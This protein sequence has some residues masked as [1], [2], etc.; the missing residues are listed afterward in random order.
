MLVVS[1]WNYFRGYVIIRIEGLALEKFINICIAEQIFLWDINR[2]NY[3]TLEAK[4]SLK[5]FKA[6]RKII[7]K[8][9]CRV[10][11]ANKNG[12]PFWFS[13]VKKRKMLLLGA[14]FSVSFLIILLSFIYRIEIQGN[15]VVSNDEIMSSL[16]NSGLKVGTNRYGLDLRDIENNVLMEIN[17]LSW[18]GI[19]IN[20]IT[21]KIKVVEKV[22]PP[23]KIDKETPTNVVAKTNGVIHK[24]IARNGDAV[25]KVGDIV[26]PGDLLITGVVKRQNLENPIYV[27]AYGEVFAKTYYET[28]KY[29][30]LI[31]IKKEKTDKMITRRT[32][33]IGDM[34]I[35]F[36]RGNIP[37]NNYVV[38]SNVKSLLN[39]KKVNFPVEIIT[40]EY[41]EAI[42][43]EFKVDINEAKNKLHEQAIEE[44]VPKIPEESEMVHSLVNFS[45]K[46]DVLYLDLVIETIEEI[47]KQIIINY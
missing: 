39:W 14:F 12:Y 38:E 30:N 6:I 26:E 35:A 31:E 17:E 16:Y 46:G 42:D 15:M 44:L 13:R 10:Y 41:Y 22:F 34:V 45:R 23:E 40:D 19:E 7:R 28:T 1:L 4:V 3:T 36:S 20:G 11:I 27:H 5:G 32:I 33:K 47:G 25:V 18:V 29:M 9:G 21:A 8:A 37:F 2:I 24:V 43:Y